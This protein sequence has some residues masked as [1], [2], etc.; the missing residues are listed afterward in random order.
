MIRTTSGSE[1]SWTIRV[2]HGLLDTA[3]WPQPTIGPPVAL[4]DWAAR[5]MLGVKAQTQGATCL[6]AGFLNQTQPLLDMLRHKP[7]QLLEQMDYLKNLIISSIR[8]KLQCSWMAVGQTDGQ[9][10]V[11]PVV[12][13][14]IMRQLTYG[15]V[16]PLLLF[17]LDK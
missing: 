3:R 14:G 17:L 9:A 10:V 11:I 4:L 5:P 6:M 7:S 8:Q 15:L 12:V 16:D 13:P 1:R 2:I